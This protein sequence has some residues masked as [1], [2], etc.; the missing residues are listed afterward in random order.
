VVH[1][2]VRQ[3]EAVRGIPNTLQGTFR[4][5]SGNIQETFRD[6]SGNIQIKLKRTPVGLYLNFKKH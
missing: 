5:H 3:R 6:Y 4:E 1:H 2:R